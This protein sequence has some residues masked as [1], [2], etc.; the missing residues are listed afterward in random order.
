MVTQISERTIFSFCVTCCNK[1]SQWDL[2]ARFFDEFSTHLAMIRW[3]SGYTFPNTI[4]CPTLLFERPEFFLLLTL[5]SLLRHTSVRDPAPHGGPT[6]AMAFSFFKLPDRTQRRTTF[7]RTVRDEWSARR[8]DFYL[9]THN[10][11]KRQASLHPAGFEPTISAR[12]RQQTYAFERKV[13]G[14][15][16][17]VRVREGKWGLL[18]HHR[19]RANLLSKL[20]WL[21]DWIK[22]WLTGWLTPWNTIFFENE[23]FLS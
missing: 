13:S 5:S 16:T 8:T 3:T 7:G 15:S 2:K 6:R 22:N 18:F 10:T 17:S 23:N 4:S 20:D 14:T 21:T 1:F 11:Q 12:E 19:Y 9:T